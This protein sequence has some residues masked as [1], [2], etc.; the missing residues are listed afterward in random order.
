[1]NAIVMSVV[2]SLMMVSFLNASL[3]IAKENKKSKDFFNN[4]AIVSEFLKNIRVDSN[5]KNK[6][7]QE[8]EFYYEKIKIKRKIIYKN[9]NIVIFDIIFKFKREEFKVEYSFIL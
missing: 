6:L 4:T 5:L 7:L 9:K 8:K 2:I 3:W 1:M